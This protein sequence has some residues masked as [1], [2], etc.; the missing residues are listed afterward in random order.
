M[1]TKEELADLVVSAGLGAYSPLIEG[2]AKYSIRIRTVPM[3]EELIALGSSKLGGLPDLP[4]GK[5]WPDR[6]GM[7]LAFI[8]QFQLDEVATHDFDNTLPHSGLLY[9]FYD[10]VEMPWG[11]ERDL[12]AW[13]VFWC[14]MARETLSRTSAPDELPAEG[15]FTPCA[16]DFSSEVTLPPTRSVLVQGLLKGEALDRYFDLM[17]DRE[18]KDLPKHRLLGHPD[19]IQGDMQ[20]ECTAAFAGLDPDKV[21]PLELREIQSS[22]NPLIVKLRSEMAD[23]RLL[24]QIDSDAHTGMMWHDA[25]LIFYWIHQ[26]SVQ[27]REFTRT[28]LILQ[29]F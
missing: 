5:K 27:G 7:P 13:Q 29:C 4:A 17:F 6:N 22:K 28:W 15:R 11:F 14:D 23:W 2:M 21:W 9:F 12:G 19:S 10:A 24:L 16:V 8:A 20:P 26:Q 1:H 18:F 3:S 25:G